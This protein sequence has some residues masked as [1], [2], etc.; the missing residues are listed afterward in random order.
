M[1]SKHDN[2]FIV[3]APHA[4]LEI[5]RI[6]SGGVRVNLMT[7]KEAMFLSLTWEETRGLKNWLNATEGTRPDGPR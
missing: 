1:V 7:A 6:D 5:S 4:D 2:L 3:R